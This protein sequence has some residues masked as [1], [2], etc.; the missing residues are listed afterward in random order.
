[1][2]TKHTFYSRPSVTFEG[3]HLF[4]VTGRSV[5]REDSAVIAADND[6]QA[7]KR[8]KSL[9]RLHSY[10][11]RL[12]KRGQEVTIIATQ[13]PDPKRVAVSASQ[14]EALAERTSDAY[15]HDRYAS[16]KACAAALLR[17]G[18]T[19]QQAEEIL[20]SKFT[21][22]AADRSDAPYGHATASDLLRFMDR[23]QGSTHSLL[24]E[25]GLS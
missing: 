5:G 19:D 13:L 15:S 11:V 21:R 1:M 9:D 14:I 16:W 7:C 12:K 3:A 25:M 18:Y 10:A 17:R 24:A 23:S 4:E 20:R 2:K 22:W 8:F 6:R